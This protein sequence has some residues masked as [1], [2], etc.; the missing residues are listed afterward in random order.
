[1]LTGPAE[2]LS[3]SPTAGQGDAGYHE[4]DQDTRSP[5]ASPGVLAKDLMQAVSEHGEGWQEERGDMGCVIG[6][7]RRK[8]LKET[9]GSR[10][11][12]VSSSPL[13]LLALGV[14]AACIF[15]ARG[16]PRLAGLE[17][18]VEGLH[19]RVAEAAAAVAVEG[20]LQ[21]HPRGTCHCR[22]HRGL[23]KSALREK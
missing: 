10:G 5:Q 12:P 19:L 8:I 21:T 1:M 13:Q 18:E 16:R 22:K 20:H 15:Q 4:D 3:V 14:D 2:K 23:G 11:T 17:Q 6:A 9:Q 7:A